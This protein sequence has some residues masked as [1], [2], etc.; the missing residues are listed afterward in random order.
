MG[1]WKINHKYFKAIVQ[2]ERKKIGHYAEGKQ[3]THKGM[4]PFAT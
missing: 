4:H 2:L 1:N 3:D